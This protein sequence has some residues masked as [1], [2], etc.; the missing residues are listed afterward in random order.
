MKPSLA[1][2][3]FFVCFTA[4]QVSA[5]PVQLIKENFST[6]NSAAMSASTNPDWSDN[7]SS[8]NAFE[9]YNSGG[10]GVRGMSST[11]DHDNNI[12]TANITIP[13][14]VEVNHDGGLITLIASLPLPLVST[15]TPAILSFFAG[16]RTANG[17]LPTVTV[18]NV[19]DNVAILATSNITLNATRSIWT[20]NS[21]NVNFSPSD[22]GDTIQVRWFGGGSN[23]ADGLQL[24]D[25]NFFAESIPE[26]TTAALGLLGVGGLML[27]R[28]RMA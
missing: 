14:G 2:G 24:T 15:S 21:F 4:G 10:A 18:F 28:R 27:R 17:S 20:F 7:D 23:G 5:I 25:I 6:G 26:P 13:G 8:P 1:I 9:V 11:Y 3:A 22:I 19:T 16:T 12:G